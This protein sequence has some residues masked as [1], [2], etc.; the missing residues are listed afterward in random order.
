MVLVLS[1]VLVVL[2]LLWGSCVGVDGGVAAAVGVALCGGG[3]DAG[4]VAVAVDAAVVGCCWWCWCW[5]CCVVLLVVVALLCGVVDVDDVIGGGVGVDY[6]GVCCCCGVCV[7][8]VG[9]ACRC[10]WCGC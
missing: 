3:V 1:C 9:C 7:W 5:S 8:C 2:L 4:A 10:L 6:A